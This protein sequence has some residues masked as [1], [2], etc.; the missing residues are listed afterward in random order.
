MMDKNIVQFNLEGKH[1]GNGTV[2]NKIEGYDE[3]YF[4]SSSSDNYLNPMHYL[5]TAVSGC[6]QLV[7][8]SISK[9]I[10][11]ELDSLETKINC[12]MD[13]RGAKGDP[14]VSPYP[15]YMHQVV[16]IKTSQ[17]DKLEDLV[18][19]FERRCP[20]YNLIKDTNMTYIVE[21]KLL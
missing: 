10:D 11:M 6:T 12:E 1:I 15:K 4:V 18:N 14:N 16:E 20:M 5:I 19:E 13:M 8:G 17:P 2:E 9:E 21:Y 3:K 7:L